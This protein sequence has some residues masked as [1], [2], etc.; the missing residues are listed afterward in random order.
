M[1]KFEC[2]LLFVGFC[3]FAGVLGL[4]V[5]E[6]AETL[7]RSNLP[8]LVPGI[9]LPGNSPPV[10]RLH[11]LSTGRFFCSGTVVS[12]N[13][14]VTAGHCL[15][16]RSRAKPSI[17]I[18]NIAGEADPTPAIAAFYDG[19]SDQGLILGDFSRFNSMQFAVSPPTVIGLLMDE[20]RVIATCGFPYGGDILCGTFTNRHQYY[21][22]IAGQGFLYPGMSGGPV[23]DI[24]SGVLLGAN[25]AVEGNYIII[26]PL[27]ELLAHAGVKVVQ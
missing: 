14:A 27:V 15:E 3:F 16:G 23:F 12:A 5:K 26:G 13:Y 22:Q 8:D 9:N 24:E 19:R 17:E 4:M 11:D 6:A 10:I 20:T 7:P 2:F 21:F 18:R 1:K 25:Y